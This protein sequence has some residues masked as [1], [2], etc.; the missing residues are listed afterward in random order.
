M[1][2]RS[3]ILGLA[4]NLLFWPLLF[5]M[6]ALRPEYSHFTK[7]VS[8]LGTWDAPR[9]WVWNLLGY[10]VPGLLLAI[11]GWQTGRRFAPKARLLPGLFV[12][13]G[14]F[15]TLSGIVPGDMA[16]MDSATTRIHLLGAFGSLAAYILAL[17]LLA[18]K[19]GGEWRNAAK[20][21]LGCLVLL[22]ASVVLGSPHGPGLAQRLMFAVFLASYPALA[23]VRPRP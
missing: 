22:A 3:L 17:I 2:N 4:A 9:M 23:L 5:V 21:A 20:L 10:I 8:E 18:L 1:A 16:H 15:M 11:A 6:A 14:L 12:L 13:A 19:L 7:A